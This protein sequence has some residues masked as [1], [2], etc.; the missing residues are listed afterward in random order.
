MNFWKVS[1]FPKVGSKVAWQGADLPHRFYVLN[2]NNDQD[3]G[4]YT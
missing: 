4:P 1:T 2:K 3:R